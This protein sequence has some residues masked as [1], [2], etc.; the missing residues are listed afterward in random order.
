MPQNLTFA[1]TTHPL[2]SGKGQHG[3]LRIR[4]SGKLRSHQHRVGSD[5]GD[6]SHVVG[7]LQTAFRDRYYAGRNERNDPRG[8]PGIDLEAFEVSVVDSDD[9]GLVDERQLELGFVANFDKD[10]EADIA[11]GIQQIEEQSWFD[12]AD[13][14]Q[15]SRSAEGF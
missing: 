13:D 1:S 14:Y 12:G 6:P 9:V 11:A 10:V 8:I 4:R 5:L 7:R 2:E 15:S 3:G